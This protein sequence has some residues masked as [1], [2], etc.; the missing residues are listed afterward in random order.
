MNLY[1]GIY[2]LSLFVWRFFISGFSKHVE[3]EIIVILFSAS[4]ELMFTLTLL[5]TF[6]ENVCE[7]T[8]NETQITR[9]RGEVAAKIG[10]CESMR[11]VCG[12]GS[13]ADWMI[14]VAAFDDIIPLQA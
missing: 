12:D 11:Q 14:P 4:L 3:G 9:Y 5:W 7:L 2:S 10:C 13:C 8:T 6:A 1:G